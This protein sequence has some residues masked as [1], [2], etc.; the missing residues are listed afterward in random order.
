MIG[1]KVMEAYV[2]I[3]QVP[4]CIEDQTLLQLSQPLNK[5]LL[6]WVCSSLIESLNKKSADLPLQ[7]SVYPDLKKIIP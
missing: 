1:R 5:I 7:K 6:E 3:Y 2:A 4:S